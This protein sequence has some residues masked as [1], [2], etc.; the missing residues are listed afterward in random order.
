[1]NQPGLTKDY[2]HDSFD[3]FL[4]TNYFRF[5][6]LQKF[7]DF[8]KRPGIIIMENQQ[9]TEVCKPNGQLSII[10]GYRRLSVKFSC[11]LSISLFSKPKD[12]M[13][14]VS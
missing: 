1:M 2:K 13:I 11:L 12:V 9:R 7:S 8:L 14:S 4:V 6:I 3:V 5:L 10:L